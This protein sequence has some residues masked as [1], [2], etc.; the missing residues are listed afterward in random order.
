MKESI[1]NCF[2]NAETERLNGYFEKYEGERMPEESLARLREKVLGESEKKPAKKRGFKR[3][4]P[5]LSAA[6]CLL[7]GLGIAYKAGA[8]NKPNSG[9]P[10][11]PDAAQSANLVSGEAMKLEVSTNTKD[12][13]DIRRLPYGAS[14]S[15][16]ADR[17]YYRQI[18]FFEDGE[19]VYAI[20]GELGGMFGFDGE[21]F[22]RI[23]GAL[24]DILYFA[25]DAY[26]GRII[27][28]K[29]QHKYLDKWIN[30]TTVRDTFDLVYMQNDSLVI[31]N[32][33][34]KI[35][36]FHR[37]Q[38]ALTANAKANAMAEKQDKKLKDRMDKV[39]K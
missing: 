3:L 34:G 10:H 27:L 8:F 21:S 7:I 9:V 36:S 24:S 28:V 6:A 11:K 30:K 16:Q 4:I 26:N 29:G 39:S 18:R 1:K 22:T 23:F 32:H 35:Y 38:N 13:L 2:D 25:G 17:D 12:K 5:A 20:T 33:E 37:Q 31:R 14:Q 19:K 15:V